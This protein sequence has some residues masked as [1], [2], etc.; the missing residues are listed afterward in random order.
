[1][2][3]GLSVDI[4]DGIAW[5]RLDRPKV[6]NA[7]DANVI[8]SLH[9]ALDEVGHPK[10]NV[11]CVVIGGQ[12]ATFCSGI[13]LHPFVLAKDSPEKTEDLVARHHLDSL[14][15]RLVEFQ[16][17]IIAAVQ[18]PAIGAGMTLALTADIMVMSEQA[19]L[20]PSF[21]RLG[22]CRIRASPTCCRD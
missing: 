19:Y 22:W 21:T 7:I 12:G 14:V 11:R 3:S 20:Q 5:L 15:I 18:G 17:P 1:M 8:T 6:A 16:L 10:A 13:D 4:A 2:Y 9:H